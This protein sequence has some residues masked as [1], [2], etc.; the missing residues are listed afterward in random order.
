MEKLEKIG[1][2]PGS[3]DPF[4][5]GHS[6]IVNM[7]L[8]IFD[9]VIIC[10]AI[11]SDKTPFFPY[12][13]REDIIKEIYKDNDRVEV[14][15]CDGLVSMKAAELNATA[16]IKGVRDEKDFGYEMKQ[17]DCNMFINHIPTIFIPSSPNLS[18]ISSTLI[19]AIITGVKDKKKI[20]DMLFGIVNRKFYE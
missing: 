1:F 20:H 18:F 12:K 4:H 5:E 17:A 19:R 7:A 16:I 6:Y 8:D 14:V 13:Q 9:K 3:F 2:Y 15:L 10:I 11:N